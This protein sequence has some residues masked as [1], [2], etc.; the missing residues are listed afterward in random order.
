MSEWL[1][2][3][4][5]S[6]VSKS[7]LWAIIH[8]PFKKKKKSVTF[9][10][11]LNYTNEESNVTFTSK[12]IS[13]EDFS[14]KECRWEYI[15]RKRDL[16]CLCRAFDVRFRKHHCPY[17]RRRRPTEMVEC[18]KCL[19]VSNFLSLLLKDY[20]LLLIVFYL[21]NVT[22]FNCGNPSWAHEEMTWC[23]K[24]S[25]WHFCH[26]WFGAILG[27]LNKSLCNI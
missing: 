13:T 9:A 21:F 27:F 7:H 17:R 18:L 22:T 20:V 19:K 6:D 8:S 3:L 16:L 4:M 12:S 11:P 10:K 26:L 15:W 2:E 5:F 25:A 24:I 1:P 23:H 14:V